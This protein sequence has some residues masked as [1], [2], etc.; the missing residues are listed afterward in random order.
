MERHV[1]DLE[2]RPWSPARHGDQNVL[3]I[4]QREGFNLEAWPL[5]GHLMYSIRAPC[6]STQAHTFCIKRVLSVIR[7]LS[8]SIRPKARLGSILVDHCL[9]WNS[10]AGHA[11]RT[12]T[13]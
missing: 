12:P 13:E 10:I 6:L 9:L 7:L 5:N 4:Q 8:L 3:R 2:G 11:S 1:L